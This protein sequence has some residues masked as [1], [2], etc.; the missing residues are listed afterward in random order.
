VLLRHKRGHRVPVRV[1]ATAVR[2]SD[3]KVIGAAEVFEEHALVN[4]ETQRMRTLDSLHLVD[5]LTGLANHEMIAAKLSER[6]SELAAYRIPFGILLIDIDHL[7]RINRHFGHDAGDS[8]LRM[9]AQTLAKSVSVEHLLGRWENDR[10]LAIVDNCDPA[11]LTQIGERLRT[12]MARS[13]IEWWGEPVRV[14]VSVAGA[15]ARPGESEEA[16]LAR[17]ARAL[18][19]LFAAGGDGFLIG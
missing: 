17:A 11:L 14:T 16:L 4:A 18:A 19:T 3:G 15:V 2:D 13:S 1:R 7:E 12:M 5:R 10:F 9:T 6:F 8:I